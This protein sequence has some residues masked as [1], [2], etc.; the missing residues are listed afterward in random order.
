MLAEAPA[1]TA[2]SGDVYPFAEVE[3][4]LRAGVREAAEES[5]ALRGG[6]EPLLDSLRMVSVLVSLEDLFDSPLPPEK[7][8]MRGGYTNED[9]AYEHMSGQLRRLGDENHKSGGRS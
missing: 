3:S 6:W 9:D 8:V 4:R 2:T 5:V 7:L 1:R